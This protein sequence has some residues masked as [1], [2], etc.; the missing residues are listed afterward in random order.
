METTRHGPA[1]FRAGALIGLLG[2]AGFITLGSNAQEKKAENKAEDLKAHPTAP[3]LDREFLGAVHLGNYGTRPKKTDASKRTLNIKGE[4]GIEKLEDYYKAEEPPHIMGATVF[5]AVFRN[6]GK[7]HSDSFGTGMP[8]G[9]DRH[10]VAGEGVFRPAEGGRLFSA[11]SRLDT[12]AKY[13]VLYQVVADRGLDPRSYTDGIKPEVIDNAVKA[14]LGEEENKK[15]KFAI[16]EEKVKLE[17]QQKGAIKALADVVNKVMLPDGSIEDAQR[18]SVQLN[19]DPRYITS[20]GHFESAGFAVRIAKQNEYI[21]QWGQHHKPVSAGGVIPNN[22]VADRIEAVSFLPGVS[23]MLQ[24]AD[25]ERVRAMAYARGLVEGSFHVDDA[26]V[27]IE[28]SLTYQMAEGIRQKGGDI[29]FASHLHLPG[30]K[31]PDFAVRPRRVRIVSED[32]P[33][34]FL[35]PELAEQDDYTASAFIVDFDAKGLEGRAAPDEVR[36]IPRTKHSVVFGFTTNLD[37]NPTGKIRLDDLDSTDR[38]K[39]LPFYEFFSKK[40]VAHVPARK[41]FSRGVEEWSKE[42]GRAHV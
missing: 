34:I 13:L 22:F 23:E 18:F 30:G 28:N 4:Y 42:I 11:P 37:P 2:L 6:Q 15:I 25:F 38:N 17:Q 39:D 35:D 10:F 32:N 12:S 14:V 31:A 16:G 8:G 27:G 20:F 24:E 7:G 40:V 9:L 36:G 29:M 5:F 19:V 21:D 41:G 33:G 1:I 3:G 26:N